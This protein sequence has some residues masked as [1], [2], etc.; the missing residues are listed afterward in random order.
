MGGKAESDIHLGKCHNKIIYLKNNNLHLPLTSSC[1]SPILRCSWI[2][3]YRHDYH[4][5]EAPANKNPG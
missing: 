5:V 2:L 4:M 1:Y 3:K